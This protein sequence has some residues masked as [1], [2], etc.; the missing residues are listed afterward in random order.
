MEIS[1]NPGNMFRQISKLVP[2]CS[3]HI[4]RSRK[5]SNF[6]RMAH[7]ASESETADSETRF[8]FLTSSEMSTNNA[9]V[10]YCVVRDTGMMWHH[11]EA[12]QDKKN[13][14]PKFN[15]SN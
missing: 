4:R 1:K 8:I 5:I 7:R 3:D 9:G 6:V 10:G 14:G 11:P 12:E 15:D 2:I 13:I